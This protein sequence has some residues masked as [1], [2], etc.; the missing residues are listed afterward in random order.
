[1]KNIILKIKNIL[2]IEI[3]LKNLINILI[4]SIV[5][6]MPFVVVK[7]G[8]PKYILG[9][10]IFLY[11][12][13]V[14]ELLTFI[15]IKDF[16]INKIQGIAL[17][18]WISILI[19]SIFSNCKF[20]ALFGS[21]NRYEG[22]IT[23]TVYVFNFILVSK[24]IKVTKKSVNIVLIVASL[25]SIYGVL[26]FYGIDPIQE[27]ALSKIE[28]PNSIGTI[29][30]RNFLSSYLCIFL[31]ISM[32]SYI[33]IGKKNYLI[34]SIILFAGLISTLTRSGWFAFIIYSLVG[35]IFIFKNKIQLKRSILIFIT[36]AIVFMLINLTSRSEIFDRANNT[37]KIE[38]DGSVIIADSGRIEILKITLKAFKDRPL[39]GWGP[40]TLRERL[41][42]EYPELQ[43]NYIKN[44]NQIID[45]SHNEYLEYAVNNGVFSLFFYL[46]ILVVIL[47]KLLSNRSNYIS[48]ILFLT[49]LGYM[50]QGFFNISVIMV[51]PIFWILLGTSL[52]LIETNFEI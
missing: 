30:N 32:A 2:N 36:F 49:I 14:L 11:L 8:S 47:I 44:Y 28:V 51:A 26:Q 37:V 9:K 39:L 22:L 10:I 46:I 7:F 35:F 17:V 45:K 50:I 40:D 18:F 31:F 38:E 34:Y 29:G 33:F 27:W 24:F 41:N 4:Y 48:N 13:F 12:I 20:I 1:M 21:H 3:K 5:L 43:V 25:M 15:K 42:T 16:K 19:P 23:Y 6:I 52:K